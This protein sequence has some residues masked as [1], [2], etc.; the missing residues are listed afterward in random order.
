MGFYISLLNN[1]IRHLHLY[2]FYVRKTKYIQESLASTSI[3]FPLPLP[4]TL[5]NYFISWFLKC[6][7]YTHT[8]LPEINLKYYIYFLNIYSFIHSF[9]QLCWVL[10]VACEIFCCGMWDLVPWPGS[11]P[12]PPALGIWSL[13]HWTT[14][15]VPIYTFYL[16]FFP[17]KH[18]IELI[19]PW[20]YIKIG[21]FLF[22]ATY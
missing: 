22:I 6:H 10:V 3:L 12:R 15:E 14:R 11:K 19:T 16:H 18:L 20:P 4:I 7:P 2:Q 5:S 17:I 13:S 9:I 21:F 1:Y 8:T